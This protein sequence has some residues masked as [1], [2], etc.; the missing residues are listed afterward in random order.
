MLQCLRDAETRI[1]EFI[2]LIDVPKRVD[3]L[4]VLAIDVFLRQLQ[5]SGVMCCAS[6]EC[7]DNVLGRPF[8]QLRDLHDA[9]G[10]ALAC[11]EVLFRGI[12]LKCAFLR[13]SWYMD[14]PTEIAEV[15]LQLAQYGRDGERAERGAALTIE[16]VDR[17][18]QADCRHLHQIFEGLV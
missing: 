12:D 17:E 2:G 18:Q 3:E 14:G 9:R 11:A 6:L 7:G 13:G 8:E 4:S 15:A 5:G 16:A 10:P 1:D